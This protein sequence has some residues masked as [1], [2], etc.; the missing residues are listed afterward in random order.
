MIKSGT[1]GKRVSEDYEDAGWNRGPRGWE[2]S[3]AA[4]PWK[5][6]YFLFFFINVCFIEFK[7]MSFFFKKNCNIKLGTFKGCV[8]IVG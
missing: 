8:S 5:P 1:E 4:D 3:S 7:K 2:T 6:F